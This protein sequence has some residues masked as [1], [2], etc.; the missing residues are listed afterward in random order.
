[1]ASSSTVRPRPPPPPLRLQKTPHRPTS[2]HADGQ[3]LYDLP[4][5]TSITS[6]PPDRGQLSPITLDS[7]VSPS[8]I[9]SRPQSRIRVHPANR[10]TRTLSP[11]SHSPHGRISPSPGNVDDEL[12]QFALKCRAWY[13]DQ[14]DDAG[15]LMT[16]TLTSLPP[17]IRANYAR[18]QA[19]IRA[20]YHT[21]LAARR[22][23]EFQAHLSA[24]VPG[25]SLAAHSRSNPNGPLA[26]RERWERF[27]RFVK[28]W[29]NV[30]MPGTKPFFESLWAVM[31][32]Q[33]VP[34]NL[35]GAGCKRIE[36]EFDDAV[37]MESAGKE[38]M[39]EAIDVLKGV[40][41]FEERLASR[42]SSVRL[43]DDTT[44]SRQHSRSRSEP[45][46]ALLLAPPSSQNRPAQRVYS[47]RSRAP[48]DPFVD[49]NTIPS[50]SPRSGGSPFREIKGSPERTGVRANISG[51]PLPPTSAQIDALLMRTAGGERTYTPSLASE[52]FDGGAQLHIWTAPSLSNPEFMTLLASF[53]SF[54]TRRTLPRFPVAAKGSKRFDSDLD[55]EEGALDPDDVLDK[56]RVGTGVLWIGP[57]E[58]TGPWK[59]NWWERFKSWWRRLLG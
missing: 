51:G 31:R 18:I 21:F 46:S 36:W 4:S 56:L 2:A 54:L 47:S 22:K 55:L 17:S 42:S 57:Q 58:R 10:A 25:G 38:F 19:H 14:D 26:K 50:T 35:G 13:Y 44:L 33:V 3:L 40:L 23:A 9:S 34:E 32:L 27:D 16:Q 43:S 11:P 48:S 41:G 5:A 6:P 1:M 37:F 7:P 20:S 52:N 12:E 30:G 39:L 59:G 15:R 29:C 45:L 28:A 8:R 53:P 24:T 49:S